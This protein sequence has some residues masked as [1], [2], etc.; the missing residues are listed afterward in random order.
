MQMQQEMLRYWTDRW[1]AVPAA[2][3]VPGGDAAR[4]AQKRWIELGVEL[5]DKHR[6]SLDST[7]SAGIQLIEQAFRATDARS[8]DD[9]RRLSE[10]LWRKLFDTYKAQSEA[11]WSAFQ[12]WSAKSAEAVRDV[13]A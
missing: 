3:N 13:R 5:L 7:Y 6:A 1:G 4:N 11:Q 8:P 2:A 10:E 9:Y 12:Q